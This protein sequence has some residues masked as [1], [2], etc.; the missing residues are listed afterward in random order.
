[1][2]TDQWHVATGYGERLTMEI[3]GPLVLPEDVA[4]VPVAELGPTLRE[5][6]THEPGDYCITR[7]RTR[8]M[9]SVVD[10]QTAALLERFRVPGT[11]VDAVIGYCAA[12][13]LDPRSTLEDAFVVLSGFIAAGVLVA[14]D[15]AVAQ[16]IVA[17]FL[18]GVRVGEST[19]VKP[20]QVMVD[21]EVYAA[22]APDGTATALKVARKGAGPHVRAAFVREAAVLRHLDGRVNPVLRDEGQ[23]D[24][25]PY[26]AVSWCAGVDVYQAAKEAREL[27]EHA[28]SR[29]VLQLVERVIDAYS[30]LHGQEVLHGDVH[31]RNVL[32][33]PSDGVAIIDYGLASAPAAPAE[34]GWR[35]GLDFFMEPEVAAA[36]RFGWPTPVLTAEG[37]QYALAAL[38][39]LLLTGAHTHTFSLE[40]DEMLRQ[41]LEDSPLPF[42]RQGGRDMP[43][44]EQVVRRALAKNPTERYPSVAHLLQEYRSAME[45]D[46]ARPRGRSTVRSPIGP[47]QQLLDDVLVRLAVPGA[48]FA[49]GLPA[50]T[51]SAMNGAA[52]FAYA[53]LRVAALRGDEELLALADLWSTRAVAHTGTDEAFWNAELEIVPETFGDNSFYHHASGVHAVAALVAHA[54]ADEAAEQLAVDAFTAA[55][56]R[57]CEHIDVAF[58]RAGLLL[59][60]SLIREV[61]SPTARREPLQTLG[62][63]LLEALWSELLHQPPLG[64]G[65][66]LRSLGAAHGWAGCLYAVLRWSE[67]SSSSPPPGI[68]ARL[69]Q[70]AALGHAHGRGMFWPH[71]V[72]AG[73][74]ETGLGSSW[75]NGAA[76]H[77]ILWAL[78]STSLNEDRYA[79]LAEMAAWTA[80]G[81]GSVGPGDLCCGFAGRAYALLRVYRMSGE[82]LWLS[83]VGTRRSCRGQHQPPITAPGQP[84]Q[85]RDGSSAARRGPAG[86]GPG[87]HAAVRARGLAGLAGLIRCRLGGGRRYLNVIFTHGVEPVSPAQL[88]SAPP[89]RAGEEQRGEF[90][91]TPGANPR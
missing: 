90:A 72:G 62:H 52:G 22:H 1:M 27:D 87:V 61:T 4:I 8:T 33:T 54:R 35:G 56:S 75:C 50:P 68:Q 69:E 7:P 79:R 65:S 49:G 34:T 44:V 85:G 84:V 3:L 91:A 2:D 43:A 20:V 21:T 80:Y 51:A 9:S 41:L 30:H 64:D 29:E 16:P 77:A 38:V 70:L 10:A 71:E 57:P 66:R 32:V 47:G 39:Y 40:Q 36:R 76:G 11:M 60:C 19:V 46:E 6:I 53:L 74:A 45:R 42:Q 67:A 59:G 86:A 17:S 15:S 23:V 83:R 88:P 28:G 13:G 48:L 5:R 25:Q 14:A 78:A 89:G 12:E 55:A 63:T 73:A 58:G 81:G 31:P 82:A 26:L 37:E 24:E 18:A